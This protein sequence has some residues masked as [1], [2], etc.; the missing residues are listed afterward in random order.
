MNNS[1]SQDLN[2][3]IERGNEPGS[4]R[5]CGD[6]LLLAGL[7]L[8]RLVPTSDPASSHGPAGDGPKVV[9]GSIDECTGSA[10]HASIST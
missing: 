5:V 3:A 2:V 6:L 1:N 10:S 7:W 8:A 9:A 4:C